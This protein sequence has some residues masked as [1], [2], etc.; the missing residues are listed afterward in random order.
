MNYKRT[1]RDCG[2][3]I[4]YTEEDKYIVCPYCGRRTLNPHYEEVEYIDDDDF[5]EEVTARRA[6]QRRAPVSR[7]NPRRNNKKSNKKALIAIIAS[8]STAV[9]IGLIVLICFAVPMNVQK[10]DAKQAYS[11]AMKN[12]AAATTGTITAIIEHED[13][14]EGD[15]DTYKVVVSYKDGKYAYCLEETDEAT[16]L[17][18]YDYD[19]GKIYESEETTRSSYKA[20]SKVSTKDVDRYVKNDITYALELYEDFFG[21]NDVWDSYEKSY[22]QWGNTVIVFMDGNDIVTITVGAKYL[23]SIECTSSDGD[24]EYRVK[25]SFKSSYESIKIDKSE[26]KAA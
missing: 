25:I 15:I 10:V 12:T 19:E 24:E 13:Y 2:G 11:Q 6:P 7:N 8:V 18:F 16:E 14:D 4:F 5:I 23:K 22:K 1:C 17:E 20:Y 9:L 3:S 21:S 26:Y